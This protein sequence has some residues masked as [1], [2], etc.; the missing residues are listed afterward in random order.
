MAFEEPNTC[1]NKLFLNPFLFR[2]LPWWHLLHHSDAISLSQ[3]LH[4]KQNRVAWWSVKIPFGMCDVSA[5]LGAS[6][7]KRT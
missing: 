6:V 7:V 5:R 4:R 2:C 1:L 3:P